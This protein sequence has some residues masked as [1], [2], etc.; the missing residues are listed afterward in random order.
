MVSAAFADCDTKCPPSIKED[1]QTWK[2]KVRVK[3]LENLDQFLNWSVSEK[4]KSYPLARPLQ[5]ERIR[6]DIPEV[7]EFVQKYGY[8][9]AVR[10][11]VGKVSSDEGDLELV[12]CLLRNVFE[13]GAKGSYLQV[14]NAEILTKILAY[15]DLKKGQ[16]I[17][18]PVENGSG[19][20]YEPFM[21]DHVFDI[22]RGM[23]A[24]GLIPQKEG[25]SSIL[26]F[27]GTEFSLVSQRGW[28]SMM[29]DLDMAG[30]GRAAF[31]RAQNEISVWLKKVKSRGKKAAVMGYSL[32]G[33]LAAYTF[34]YENGSLSDQ[35]SL[36]VCAPG[37]AEKV[38]E[39]W[40][41]LSKEKQKG[42]TS[43]V[44]SGDVVS[45]VGKLFG[46]VYCL[47]APESFK[48]IEAHMMLMCSE[49]LFTKALV[50]VNYQEPSTSDS[51]P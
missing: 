41:M 13:K 24:F 27:R 31:Q 39:D 34:I 36:A 9:S 43:Y 15:R 1:S 4:L 11:L 40:G 46:T 32:G 7:R 18:I 12:C 16:I 35:G 49:P 25:L 30:P 19:V 21:V 20:S 8:F 42:F 29:S 2:S 17:K 48:P 22:W 26:L 23:P 10:P 6:S 44:N 37:V 45:K 3:A 50:N 47:S 33:A 28:A 14:A 51:A 5:E 38:I